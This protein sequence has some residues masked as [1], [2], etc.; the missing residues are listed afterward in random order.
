MWLITSFASYTYC[1]SANCDNGY[2]N[3]ASTNDYYTL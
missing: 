3:E 2:S 1:T